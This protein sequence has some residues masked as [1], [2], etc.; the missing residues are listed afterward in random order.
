MQARTRLLAAC[1][2]IVTT[3]GCTPHVAV[4][5]VPLPVITAADPLKVTLASPSGAISVTNDAQHPLYL[6]ND[7]QHPL[8]VNVVNVVH[9]D[10]DHPGP[11]PAASDPWAEIKNALRLVSSNQPIVFV[12]P[13]ANLNPCTAPLQL[14][15]QTFSCGSVIFAYDNVVAVD[16]QRIILR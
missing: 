5:P 8:Y 13:G 1:L 3:Q 4:D 16:N 6:A 2:G 10:V 12:K 7:A 15:S 9:V 14:Q 11:T